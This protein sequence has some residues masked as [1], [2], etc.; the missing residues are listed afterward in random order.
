MTDKNDL[1]PILQRIAPDR[2]PEAEAAIYRMAYG[3][4]NSFPVQYALAMAALTD[5]LPTVLE[6]INEATLRSAAL[7]E[8]ADLPGLAASLNSHAER[9]AAILSEVRKTSD[10]A[11]QNLRTFRPLILGA[12]LLGTALVSFVVG[13]VAGR[14]E[15]STTSF[16]A[17]A[18][19]L[20]NGVPTAEA[21]AVA[22][23]IVTASADGVDMVVT[24]D[25]APPEVTKSSDA[26]HLRYSPIR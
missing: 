20:T 23:I 12:M 6:G 24:I 9:S 15:R 10:E 4:P 3:D 13:V 21:L 7:T 26:L 16:D 19:Q 14:F 25:P 22:G 8:S 5:R 2:Q 18:A 17:V 11:K 1:G